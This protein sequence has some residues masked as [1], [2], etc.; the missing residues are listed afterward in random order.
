MSN[1]T[2]PRLSD[3]SWRWDSRFQVSVFCHTSYFS[4][5]LIFS[6][7]CCSLC[8]LS[9]HYVCCHSPG[10]L[11]LSCPCI[12]LRRWSMDSR[13]SPALWATVPPCSCWLSAPALGPLNCILQLYLRV[14]S[15]Q[16]GI[17]VSCLNTRQ[18]ALMNVSVAAKPLSVFYMGT[19]FRY[20][21][22]PRC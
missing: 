15:C 9:C 4:P 21:I 14:N 22:F 5:A 6:V 20:F 16:G 18:A 1:Q 13:T 17:W 7:F 12:L 19:W 2:K 11:T 3:R 8:S 10:C